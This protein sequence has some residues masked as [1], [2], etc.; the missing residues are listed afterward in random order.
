M[1]RGG[2]EA[3]KF[4]LEELFPLT[5][6]RTGEVTAAVLPMINPFETEQSSRATIVI[7]AEAPEASE[8]NETMRLLPL[9]PQTPLPVEEQEIKL[10]DPGRLSVTVTDEAGSGPLFVRVIV[11]VTLLPATIVADEA[12]LLIARSAAP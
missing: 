2:L 9:P 1:V 10:S 5:G 8:A 3:V 6:S 12:V 7:V 4:T 11:Y